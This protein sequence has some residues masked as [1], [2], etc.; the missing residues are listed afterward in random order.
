VVDLAAIFSAGVFAWTFAEYVIHAWLSHSFN[1]F[2]KPLH[3]VHHRDP[4]AVFTIRAWTPIA[5]SWIGGL[6]LFG[7]ASGMIFY[8]G[9]VA[10]FILYEVIHYRV[11]FAVPRG[12]FEV[13]LRM[14]H[15][16]HH[17]VDPAACF[18]VTSALWDWIFGS[19]IIGTEMKRSAEAL[20]AIPPLVGPTNVRRLARLGFG[21]R[22]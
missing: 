1:T 4:H 19:E 3:A 13:Y 11:H 14:R 20:L 21:A 8:S 6:A 17:F 22:W 5:L 18:G 12:R 7:W 16:A 10:G 9:M 2:A 15:L